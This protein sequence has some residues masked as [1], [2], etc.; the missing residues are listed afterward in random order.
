MG[1]RSVAI[2]VIVVIVGILAIIA[3]VLFIKNNSNDAFALPMIGSL[4]F[5]KG[6]KR[7]QAD[8]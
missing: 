1:D 3:L 4:P 7:V 6:R 2:T 8:S 5:L